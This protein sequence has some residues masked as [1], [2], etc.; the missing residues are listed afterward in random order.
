MEAAA[1]PVYFSRAPW[2][3]TT[4]WLPT[5]SIWAKSAFL[6]SDQEVIDQMW[7]IAWRHK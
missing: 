2:E 1:D 5:A 7:R 6:K 4:V 3:A